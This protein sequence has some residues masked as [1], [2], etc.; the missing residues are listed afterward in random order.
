MLN[1]AEEAF[2][3]LL[4]QVA[5]ETGTRPIE[6]GPESTETAARVYRRLADGAAVAEIYWTEGRGWWED[7]RGSCPIRTDLPCELR[8]A[9]LAEAAVLLMRRPHWSG[10]I[11]I[12]AADPDV[13]DAA[14]QHLRSVGAPP[15]CFGPLARGRTPW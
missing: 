9:A 15:E 5:L 2:Q 1:T 10:Y 7:R 13:M 8:C 4:F 3:H 11:S 12:A 14:A 6:V